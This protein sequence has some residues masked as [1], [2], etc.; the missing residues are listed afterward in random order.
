MSRQI[1][2]AERHLLATYQHLM[3]PEDRM[4][5]RSLV[6]A[7]FDLAQIPKSVWRRIWKDFPGINPQD[8]WKL[9]IDICLRLLRDHR[10]ELRLPS[11]LGGKQE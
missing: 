8:P 2:E 1:N 4:V 11:H 9:P 7:E 6:A 3:P 10:S 5:A